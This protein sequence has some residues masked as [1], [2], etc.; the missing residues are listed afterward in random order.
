MTRK[1]IRKI[2]YLPELF[3]KYKVLRRQD[4]LDDRISAHDLEKYLFACN[5][6]GRHHGY[7]RS[8]RE[9]KCVDSSGNP[10]PWYTYPVIEQLTRWDFSD[11][12][13]LEFGCGNSTRWWAH[14]ARSVVSI[15]GSP[16]WYQR[17]LDQKLLPENV[18]PILVR[19]DVAD[20]KAALERYAQAIDGLGE[21]DVI[22]IDGETDERTRYSC[23]RAAINHLKPNG[24]IVLDNSDWL[25]DT[26]SLLRYAGLTQFDYCGN[27]PLNTHTGITSLFL[28]A[29]FKSKPLHQ[30][31]PGFSVGGLRYNL[32]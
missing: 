3:R 27:S 20:R 31:H 15:E 13:V 26:C 30:L 10:I 19:V 23:A 6:I 5:A 16:D 9:G 28:G 2:A 32:G 7:L 22:V 1:L 14:R 29:E 11:C 24:M 12:N 21:F 8:L 4:L 25:P 17:I 18:T